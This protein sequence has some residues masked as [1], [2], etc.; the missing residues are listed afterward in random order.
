MRFIVPSAAAITICPNSVALRSWCD[1]MCS[2]IFN[3]CKLDA[4]VPTYIVYFRS[5]VDCSMFE[6]AFSAD[7][8]LASEH[9]PL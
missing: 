8:W 4:V 6:N 2:D 1:E 3:I 5:R 7:M 9:Q